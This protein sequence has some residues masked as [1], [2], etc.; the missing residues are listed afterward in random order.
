MY[1]R[2]MGR[3]HEKTAAFEEG[4]WFWYDEAQKWKQYEENRASENYARTGGGAW[5]QTKAFAIDLPMALNDP[6][7]QAQGVANAANGITNVLTDIANPIIQTSPLGQVASL[8]G[9]KIPLIPKGDWSRGAFAVEYDNFASHDLSVKS[10]E[11]AGSA[12]LAAAPIPVIGVGGQAARTPLALPLAPESQGVFQ[13][14]ARFENVP[15]KLWAKFPAGVPR[16]TGQIDLLNGKPYD[17][18]RLAADRINRSLSS[19]LGLNKAGYQIHEIVP[20][21]FG[22][23]PT[24]L[25]NKVGLIRT[26]HQEVT[27]WFGRLQRLIE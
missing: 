23:S 3:A 27:T 21:K 17:A 7:E 12:F 15:P 20:V 5:A 24:A 10:G 8:L 16:P 9:Y 14:T 13:L 18:A 6:A 19:G 25:S 26:L 11:V 4:Y 1:G 2:A 22:G